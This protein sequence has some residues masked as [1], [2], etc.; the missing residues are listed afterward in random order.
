M[1][2]SILPASVHCYA[3]TTANLWYHAT[4]KHGCIWF[5]ICKLFGIFC[6][7]HMNWLFKYKFS[8]L[9]FQSAIC[10]QQQ[11]QKKIMASGNLFLYCFHHNKHVES[12]KMKTITNGNLR[13]RWLRHT[14]QGFNACFHKPMDDRSM[15][16][17]HLYVQS[18]AILCTNEQYVLLSAHN[19]SNFTRSTSQSAACWPDEDAD[20]PRWT[21]WEHLL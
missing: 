7:M 4:S 15:S 3:P 19:V 18:V 16:Q 20:S 8:L 10:G 2:I 6:V 14:P 17:I 12:L 21:F 11:Q 13:W 1:P 9:C 5:S